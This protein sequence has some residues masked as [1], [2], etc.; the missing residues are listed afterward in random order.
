MQ[1]RGKDLIDF[2][3]CIF[4][5]QLYIFNYIFFVKIKLATQSVDSVASLS[6]FEFMEI[7]GYNNI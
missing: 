1:L 4:F 7:I 3:S 6:S 2:L 5:F